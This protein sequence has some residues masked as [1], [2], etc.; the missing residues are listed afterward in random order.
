M[1]TIFLYEN[2]LNQYKSEQSLSKFTIKVLLL[3]I[4]GIFLG[5]YTDNL[6]KYIQYKY[7][8]NNLITFFYTIIFNDNYIIFNNKNK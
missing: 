3:V 4:P 2:N 5:V 6:V 7:N 1:D 8:V